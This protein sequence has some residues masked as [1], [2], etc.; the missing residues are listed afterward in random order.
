MA[1]LFSKVTLEGGGYDTYYLTGGIPRDYD[2][3]S[4]DLDLEDF[5]ELIVRDE[6]I[7]VH[8]E[9]YLYAQDGKIKC[10]IW[11]KK[12]IPMRWSPLTSPVPV[13]RQL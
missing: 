13:R 5:L 2:D 4:C 8:I 6:E 3:L 11:S 10:V 7:S 9:A 1:Y 12:P